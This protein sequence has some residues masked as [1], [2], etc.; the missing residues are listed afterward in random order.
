IGRDFGPSPVHE[1]AWPADR[2]PAAR[3][4]LLQLNGYALEG[5]LESLQVLAAP[6]G[7]VH[8]VHLLR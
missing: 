7:S 6:P 4:D 2:P 8:T 5:E 3:F 1:L